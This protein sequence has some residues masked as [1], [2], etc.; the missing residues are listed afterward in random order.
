MEQALE[1]MRLTILDAL[2]FATPE[3]PLLLETPAGQG[4]ETL[5][6]RTEFLDFVVSFGD[7]RLALCVDTCHV[8]TCGH[9]PLDYVIQA[10]HTGLLRLVHFNDSET[11]C[12]ACVDRHAY[13]GTGHIGPDKMKEIAEFC[14]S[15]KVD[16][17][18][19]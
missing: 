3:C 17:V 14:A 10:H 11:A 19:E 1:N 2:E 7:P 5:K 4:T 13:I 18:V 15:V 16:M 8:F 12:G 9:D 6:D